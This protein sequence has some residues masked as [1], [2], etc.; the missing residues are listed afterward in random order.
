MADPECLQLH[1]QVW[2]VW[3]RWWKEPL[4]SVSECVHCEVSSFFLF[5]SKPMLHPVAAGRA[6]SRSEA[7]D[8]PQCTQD[9]VR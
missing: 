9:G 4:L 3:G 7:R 8:R 2:N 1:L 6:Q 5:N